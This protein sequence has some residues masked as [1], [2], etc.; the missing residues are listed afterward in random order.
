[1]EGLPPSLLNT[2]FNA[3]EYTFTAPFLAARTTA[4]RLQACA[5]MM[6]LVAQPGSRRGCGN[7]LLQ[8]MLNRSR[9]APGGSHRALANFWVSLIVVRSSQRAGLEVEVEV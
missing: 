5:Y 9:K 6:V 8:N 1:M 4:H 7:N 3:R 2:V